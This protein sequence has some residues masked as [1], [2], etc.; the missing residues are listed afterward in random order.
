MKT[1]ICIAVATYVLIAI[2][3]KRAMQPH[4]HYELLHGHHAHQT[5]WRRTMV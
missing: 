5:D 1:Q 3:T 4:S 2:V